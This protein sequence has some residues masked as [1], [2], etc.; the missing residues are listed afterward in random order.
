[1][2]G[3]S[4]TNLEAMTYWLAASA[5]RLRRAKARSTSTPLKSQLHGTTSTGD[6][7]PSEGH[8]K[9]ALGTQAPFRW[10]QADH[11][12]PRSKGGPSKLSNG[13]MING[14]DNMAK[15]DSTKK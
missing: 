5:T 3:P 12:H 4:Q 6:A 11:I 14:V 8:P 9:H 15:G 13:Q 1:M 2:S 10:L 7:K